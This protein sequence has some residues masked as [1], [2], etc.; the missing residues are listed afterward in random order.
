[1]P[2][3][4]S[5]HGHPRGPV[6]DWTLRFVVDGI[7]LDVVSAVSSGDVDDAEL[8]ESFLLSQ[9]L[10]VFTF[11]FCLMVPGACFRVGDC[12]SSGYRRSVTCVFVGGGVKVGVRVCGAGRRGA[13][14][15]A[16]RHGCHGC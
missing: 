10:A 12:V 15:R 7:C 2:Q 1:M 9:S 3:S 13:R 5:N 11:R 14:H 8:G 6:G 4:T 16:S